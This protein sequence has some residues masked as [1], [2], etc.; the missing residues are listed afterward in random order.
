MSTITYH[1]LCVHQPWATAL[2]L[3]HKP[4]E[5][6][7]WKPW[8]KILNQRTFI[9]ATKK[10][11]DL[12]DVAEV[13]KLCGLQQSEVLRWP[14]GCFVGSL[15]FVG[16]LMS[17]ESMGEEMKKWWAGPIAWLADKPKAMTKPLEWNGA[18]GLWPVPADA[19]AELS[20]PERWR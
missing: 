2:V 12:A 5:N 19:L 10:A 18:Q 6:R 9:H 15:A 8:A 14:T 3:G 13:A 17:P 11:P 20:R 1:A 7:D 4:I 16:H